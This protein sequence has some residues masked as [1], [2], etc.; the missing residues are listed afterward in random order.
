MR[1]LRGLLVP[2]LVISVISTFTPSASFA[3]PST[4]QP[5]KKC[6][7]KRGD[8]PP[9]SN[10]D[11]GILSTANTIFNDRLGIMTNTEGKFAIGAFPDKTTG[12]VTAASWD[13]S[14]RWPNGGST[15]A[16]TIRVDG[17]DYI[18][19][20]TD[21]GGTML[22]V[23]A[24][25]DARTHRTVWQIDGIEVTQTLQ[26]GLNPHT[27]QKDT[28]II[29][30]TLRNNNLL[31][32]TVGTRVMIDTE[33]NQRDGF[34]FRVPGAGIITHETD[35]TGASVPDVVLA[36]ATSMTD[37]QVTASTLKGSGATTPDRLV[38]GHWGRLS[39]NRFDF[40]VDPATPLTDDSAYAVYWNPKLLA[41]GESRTFVTLYGL[42]Q[43]TVNK[44]APLALSVRGPAALGR[45]WNDYT[46]N[47]F[48]I[49]ATISNTGTTTTNGTQLT[50]T[51]PPQLTLAGGTATQTIGALPAGQERQVSWKVRATLQHT[52]ASLSYS[53]A[54]SATGVAAK[55]VSRTLALPDLDATG[56]GPFA[57][58][59][60]QYRY[61][62]RLHK[63]VIEI[64]K[65]T[66]WSLPPPA[67]CTDAGKAPI[68]IWA[69]VFWPKDL[70]KGPYPLLVFLHGN[71]STCGRLLSTGVRVDDSPE[72]TVFGTCTGTSNII[73]PNHKGYDY[74]GQKLASWGYIVVSINANRTITGANNAYPP[75]DAFGVDG[76]VIRSRGRLVL[77]HLQL[78]HQWN[79]TGVSDA[80]FGT[81]IAADTT[82][83]G[84]IFKGK[85][86]LG[87]VG[88]MGHSRGGQGVRS[89]YVQYQP[90]TSPW[91]AASKVPNV[92]IKGVFEVAPTD[93]T[94]AGVLPPY[95]TIGTAWNVLLP[96]CDGDV[97]DLQGVQPFD[98]MLPQT[99]E[100]PATQKSSYAVWG[101][102]HNYYNTEWQTSDSDGCVGTGNTALFT[103]GATLGSPTQRQTG[104]ASMMAFFRANVGID[105]NST[106]NLNFNP[107]AT[108]P[109]VVTSVTRVDRGYSVTPNATIS[110][111][112]EDFSKAA[113]TNTA[114]VPN[115]SANI[116]INHDLIA[117]QDGDLDG[118]GIND[119]PFMHHDET[120]RVG[121]ISWTS[122]AAGNFFQT[123]WQAA[124]SG[125]D[126]ADYATLDFR[127]ARQLSALNS[128]A[129]T[130]FS[131]RLA[132]GDGSLSD[133]VQLSPYASLNGPVGVPLS[134]SFNLQHTLLQSV[135]IP[136]KDFASAKLNQVRG[137]RFTFDGT[138]TG[139]IYVANMVFSRQFEPTPFSRQFVPTGATPFSV[140]TEQV[141]QPAPQI[142]AEIEVYSPNGFPIRDAMPVLRI[143]DNEFTYSR[144]KDTSLK[145][146][147]F[148]LTAEEFAATT[149]GEPITLLYGPYPGSQ[150][151]IFG[152][153]N[154]N[155]RRFPEQLRPTQQAARD[156]LASLRPQAATAQE[157]NQ[158]DAALQRLDRTLAPG[159]W[160]DTAHLAPSSADQV[161]DEAQQIV[162]SLQGLMQSNSSTIPAPVLR[163]FIRT[164]V[165]HV[166]RGLAAQSIDEAT[167]GQQGLD[168]ARAALARGDDAALNDQFVSAVQH[169]RSAWRQAQRA[170]P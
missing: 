149:N 112:L 25:V 65:Q 116:T 133:P 47:P 126:I 24:K 10:S 157:Q 36:A 100:E 103:P 56:T 57:V 83:K 35:F 153:L 128:S 23:P 147:V 1:I 85:V 44:T 43:A 163:N 40:T 19:G 30:Y 93:F 69:N 78:W 81:T 94:R 72:Y 152:P 26:I 45:V 161:F 13:L 99:G 39:N 38:L 98:R 6:K 118:D 87:N 142:A 166:L 123:N 159:A 110:P 121:V 77:K 8:C 102:N 143:G 89:A 129:A 58:Q 3:T 31:P 41:A 12:G 75:T 168:Q 134:S 18:F 92:S 137:V 54:A 160:R 67:S 167:A 42:G 27:G 132:H 119:G 155:N 74:L 33:I 125:R 76:G 50:L 34:P 150:Q 5:E 4:T 108:L 120:Q 148:G 97:M 138:A 21:E 105:P 53:V 169:Y 106:Y 17:T 165:V 146:L 111:V 80:S 130:N 46:P 79:T 15:S 64:C 115:D 9:G 66:D 71:H 117:T 141:A 20:A 55:S 84:S 73:T 158:I 52:P 107:L 164:R 7:P 28:A 48:D 122:A 16:T 11:F 70:T 135:R 90:A 29:A 162:T 154:K 61:N 37:T 88:L 109:P 62:P 60:G 32:K 145:T 86:D 91:R 151:W 136:L 114:S 104:L 59:A 63:D 22:G 51:L 127:I 144:Y 95:E 139:A 131:I 96:M 68:D 101:A 170:T 124:G 49:T 14:Y 156:L 82:F 140:E 113:G 2:L